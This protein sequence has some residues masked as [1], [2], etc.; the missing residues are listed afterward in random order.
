MKKTIFILS[1]VTLVALIGAPVVADIN[2]TPTDNVVMV[3]NADKGQVQ[4]AD[5]A[6]TKSADTKSCDKVQKKDCSKTDCAKP[7]SKKDDSKPSENN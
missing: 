3:D 5:S 2:P 4:V 1:I 7:C 6:S